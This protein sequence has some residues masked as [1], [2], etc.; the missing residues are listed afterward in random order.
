MDTRNAPASPPCK[1][2]GN[3]DGVPCESQWRRRAREIS[4]HSFALART[5]GGTARRADSLL[6]MQELSDREHGLPPGMVLDTV[7]EEKK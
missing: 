7:F 4:S 5:A 3:N 6:M 1:M 2:D